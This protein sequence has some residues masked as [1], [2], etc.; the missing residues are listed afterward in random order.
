LERE[1]RGKE[2]VGERREKGE[3]RK[4]MG[5]ERERDEMVEGRK[6]KGER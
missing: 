3:E 1:V 6:K 4:E 5:E 2:R